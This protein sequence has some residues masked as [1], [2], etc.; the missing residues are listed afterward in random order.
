MDCAS[1]RAWWERGE[2]KIAGNV[3][4][5]LQKAGVAS[6]GTPQEKGRAGTPVVH[7]PSRSLR[8]KC[9]RQ[10]S[11]VLSPAVWLSRCLCRCSERVK[12]RPQPSKSQAN[13]LAGGSPDVDTL[14]LFLRAW[15]RWPGWAVVVEGEELRM[16]DAR[17]VL[18]T[19]GMCL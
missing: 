4:P 15:A 3:H 7:L 19:D 16:V 14:L 8:L 12:A 10:R 18:A 1:T 6:A 17:V 11:Q 5:I 13:F 9:A 2:P